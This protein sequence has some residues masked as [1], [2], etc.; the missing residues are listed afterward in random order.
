MVE[1]MSLLVW[2]F[3]S[4]TR[5]KIRRFEEKKSEFQF[6]LYMYIV[7]N[8]NNNIFFIIPVRTKGEAAEQRERVVWW[9][10]LEDVGGGEGK[11]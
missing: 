4:M 2:P 1:G 3:R 8:N 7:L 5:H 10:R 9:V 6:Q 11:E